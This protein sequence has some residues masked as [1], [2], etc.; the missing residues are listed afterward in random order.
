VGKTDLEE[1]AFFG[2][3]TWHVTDR[4]QLTV[5][6]RWYDYSL[7]TQSAVDFPL[8]NTVYGGAPPDEINLV[9][10]PGGQDDDGTLFKFNTS[11]DFTEEVMGYL[12]VSEGYRIGNSNGIALCPD[13]LPPQQVACALPNEFQYF[14]DSTTNYEVGVHSQWLDRRLTVNAALY[15]IDWQDPQLAAKT[16]NAA[17]PITVNGDGAQSQ[18]LEINFDAQITDRLRVW[19]NYAYVNAELSALAPQLIATIPDAGFSPQILIDGESGDRLPGSPEHQGSLNLRYEMPVGDTWRLGFNYGI[20]AVS[21][22][23]TTTGNKGDGEA[24]AGY[25]VNFAAID[26]A[27]GAWTVTLYADNLFDKYAETGVR[28]NT[29]YL[30]T[31]ADID[32]NPVPVRYYFKETLRPLEFGL[33]FRYD[34]DL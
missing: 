24:L 28:G 5:G 2:E 23:L 20:S 29:N 14:P 15:Y 33:R 25:A 6:G 3:L 8:A 1:L 17:L 4:W 18:G 30:Q 34:F 16:A 11:F 22:V 21:D 12:T 32:G 19:G 9:F 10:E 13:P 26:L 7:E 27:S 31:A